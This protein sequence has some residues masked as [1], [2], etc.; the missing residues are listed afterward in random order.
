[1]DHIQKNQ[2]IPR[3]VYTSE[4]H[5]D[6]KMRFKLFGIIEQYIQIITEIL[7][8]GIVSG[9]FKKEL[10]S[11]AEAKLFLSIIQFTAFRYSLSGFNKNTVEEGLILWN[12]FLKSIL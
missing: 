4:V 5:L 3:I 2:G 8:D 9:V 1:M 7:N 10:D 12:S 6:E 11:S